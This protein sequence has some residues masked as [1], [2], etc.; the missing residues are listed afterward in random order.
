MTITQLPHGMVKWWAPMKVEIW[1]CF[2]WKGQDYFKDLF[3][4]IMKSGRLFQRRQYS[5][6]RK[7]EA[8]RAKEKPPKKRERKKPSSQTIQK[9]R[10]LKEKGELWF[11]K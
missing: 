5:A 3:G 8:N 2:C 11:T 10:T 4:N 1:K 9:M 6:I 7:I